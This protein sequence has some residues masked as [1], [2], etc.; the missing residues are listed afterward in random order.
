MLFWLM[1][2]LECNVDN[3]FFIAISAVVLLLIGLAIIFRKPK[4]PAVLRIKPTSLLTN[5]E[6]FM[7]RL[8]QESFPKHLILSQ[9]AFASFM[10]GEDEFSKRAIGNK[11][12]DFVILDSSLKIVTIVELDQHQY[13]TDAQAAEEKVI[14]AAGFQ[15]LRY[16][17]PEIEQMRRDLQNLTAPPEQPLKK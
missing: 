11:V 10:E 16:S 3:M 14:R 5:R 4:A 15:L 6:Q 13:R 8:L 17:I 2:F 9:V 12:A 7:Y 1:S